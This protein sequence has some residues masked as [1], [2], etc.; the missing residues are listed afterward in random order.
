MKY[1]LQVLLLLAAAQLW[2][3]PVIGSPFQTAQYSSLINFEHSVLSSKLARESN[4]WRCLLSAPE[5]GQP[6]APG[7]GQ[8]VCAPQVTACQRI[9]NNEDLAIEFLTADP[10]TSAARTELGITVLLSKSERGWCI[11]DYL[12]FTAIGHYASVICYLATSLGNGYSQIEPAEVYVT[13]E[14]HEGGRGI[15]HVE[16]QTLSLNASKFVRVNP[17]GAEIK[18]NSDTEKQK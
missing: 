10:P 6:N 8:L 13:V 11:Q 4:Q 3:D 5:V 12:K 14:I 18:S 7:T 15:S 9:W 17:S 16:Y 2:G 1:G